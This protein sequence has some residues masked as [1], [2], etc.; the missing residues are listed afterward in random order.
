MSDSATPWMATHQASLSFTISCSLLKLI[1][2]ESVMP[3]NHLI[4]CWP[5]LLLPSI[6]PSIRVF[7][8]L[9]IRCPK[10]LK[11]QL[12]HQSFWWIF[13]VDFNFLIEVEVLVSQ[14]CLALCSP[15]DCSFIMNTRFCCFVSFF[16]SYSS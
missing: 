11:L 6:F 7:L 5:L 14:L 1:S 13:K 9:H 8:A 3:S 10:L 16:L 2:I 4:L 15:M 12:Q